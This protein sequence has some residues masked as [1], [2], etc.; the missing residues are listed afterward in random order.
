M[1]KL[2]NISGAKPI[3]G[4]VPEDQVQ[5]AIE[6]GRFSLPK[7]SVNVISPDGQEGTIPA[8][9]ATKAFQSG[10]K[11]ADPESLKQLRFGTGEQQFKTAAE[12]VARGVAGPVATA[13]EVAAGVD[14]E[15]IR[16]RQEVN[17]STSLA[18]E[19]AGLLIPGGQTKLL[20]AATRAFTNPIAK[21]AVEN[22]LY[23][24]GEEAS[25]LLTKDP[26]QSAEAALS[27]V[28][29]AA[30]LGGSL[31]GAGQLASKAV[32]SKV[33]QFIGDF[34][35]RIADHMGAVPLNQFIEQGGHLPESLGSKS[36]DAVLNHG[37]K[38][39]QGIST[40][41]GATL[42]HSTGIPHAGKIGAY[43]GYKFGEKT[44]PAIGRALVD[45]DIAPK[46]FKA[47]LAYGDAVLKGETVLNKAADSM[48]KVGSDPLSESLMPTEKQRD[49]IKEHLEELK[50]DPS[51]LLTKS[52]DL[53]YYMPEHAGAMG[54]ALGRITSFLA[55]L[56]PD[57]G[58]TSMLGPNRVPS[59]TEEA[60]YNRAL[61]IAE[62]PL[63]IAQHIKQGSLTP[64]DCQAVQ[65]MYP[66]LSD[67]LKA[68]MLESMM[69]HLSG[70]QG[71]ASIPYKTILGLSLFLGMPLESSTMPQDMS[72]NQGVYLPQGPPPPDS[73]GGNLAQSRGPSAVQSKA[74]SK[75]PQSAALPSQAREMGRQSPTRK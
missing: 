40:A 69:K 65:S 70:D 15:A 1:V 13:A 48:F 56:T 66:A 6:S 2:F 28:G 67:G 30:G 17:P 53:G 45:N 29:L 62:Q 5:G 34:K 35:N 44:L 51:P 50:V 38:V 10:Y 36:A 33:G 16:S 31:A 8:D 9:Q 7:G 71:S 25:K 42:G 23:A 20:G 12:G 24:A 73:T 14:P 59:A 22:A 11:Y 43:F 21:L 18:S 49:K 52:A 72:A 46:A 75:V 74:L 27:H 68:K 32:E 39:M 64:F 4:S 54:E 37:Q 19:G 61:D 47:A 57:T 41:A 26:K 63:I 60:K 55:P 3:E 58:K